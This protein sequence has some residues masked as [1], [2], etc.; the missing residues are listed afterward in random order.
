VQIDEDVNQ[1][2]SSLSRVESTRQS[3]AYAEAA[4][5][6][7]QQKLNLGRSTSFVVLQLQRDVT[8]A[9]SDEIRALADYNKALSQLSLDEGATLERN[10][11]NVE[12]K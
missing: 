2:R 9:R 10:K 3:R 8:A 4:L 12:V 5:Q 7:E 6:A 11:I 1:V